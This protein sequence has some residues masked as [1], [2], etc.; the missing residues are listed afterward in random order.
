M[1]RHVA[2]AAILAGLLL[3]PVNADARVK[4]PESQWCQFSAR[5]FIGVA[6]GLQT[7]RPTGRA[8]P[9]TT[10]ERLPRRRRR[11]RPERPQAG[12]S[13]GTSRTTC[14]G[15]VTGA[16]SSAPSRGSPVSFEQQPR[17][18]SRPTARAGWPMT[19]WTAPSA[20]P[21][22]RTLTE[23]TQDGTV[24]RTMTVDQRRAKV[25]AVEVGR[26]DLYVATVDPLEILAIPRTAARRRA[27][28]AGRE[29]RRPQLRRGRG[30]AHR[31]HRVGPRSRLQHGRARLPGRRS[32]GPAADDDS[33]RLARRRASAR[34]SVTATLT[35]TDPD[36]TVQ[37]RLLLLGRGSMTAASAR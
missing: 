13:P 37:R 2:S 5:P 20:V 10:S 31:R 1:L 3:I 33:R 28:H 17:R 24:L 4:D 9:P 29:A 22:G 11:V 12:R 30:L 15:P 8:G 18:A 36:G 27:R 34:C 21:R 26:D 25:T 23:Y 7:A 19:V 6:G 16:R 32:R 35:G 14:S